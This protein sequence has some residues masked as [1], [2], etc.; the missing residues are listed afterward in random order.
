[1]SSSTL[2]GTIDLVLS[3]STSSEQ[4]SFDNDEILHIYIEDISQVPTTASD[5]E[6]PKS[7]GSILLGET[8]IHLEQNHKFPLAFECKYDPT[9]ASDGQFDKLC[10]EGLIVVAAEVDADGRDMTVF[11]LKS[12]AKKFEQ[13]IKLA[14]TNSYG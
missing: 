11:W 14:L 10:K 4:P 8:A 2:N 3:A 1:M 5:Q 9:K 13:N 12:G 7:S 6:H